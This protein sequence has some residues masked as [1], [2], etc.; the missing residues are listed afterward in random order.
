MQWETHC[1]EA[2][3]PEGRI[4]PHFRGDGGS[5]CIRQMFVEHRYTRPC[6]RHCR[7]S[8][9]KADILVGETE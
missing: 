5:L 2:Q 9:N 4:P 1:G 3:R 7:H 6:L 8:L